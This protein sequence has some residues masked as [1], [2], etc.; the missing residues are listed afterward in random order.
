MDKTVE[1]M[2]KDITLSANIPQSVPKPFIMGLLDL[3]ETNTLQ[4]T[5]TPMILSGKHT[6]LDTIDVVFYEYS[7]VFDC[8]SLVGSKNKKSFFQITVMVG[9]CNLV[10]VD[11]LMPNIDIQEYQIDLIR[12]W[13]Q[14]EE[15]KNI[16]I[17]EAI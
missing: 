6:F 16:L 10:D 8:T 4:D 2:H 7:V 9:P 1:E 17:L 12:E 15:F 11:Y 5:I 13:L 14:T 3:I